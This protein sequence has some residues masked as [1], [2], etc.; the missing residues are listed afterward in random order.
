[1]VEPDRGVAGDLDVLALV[2]TDGDLV[3]VVEQDVGRHQ[4]R[5]GEQAR[6]HE[7]VLP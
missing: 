5:V 4:R 2:V 6:R 3:G 1:M 7:L